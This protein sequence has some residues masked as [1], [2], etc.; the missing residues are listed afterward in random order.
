MATTLSTINEIQSASGLPAAIPD[1]V[2]NISL[3][4][5]PAI[6][7]LEV[8]AGG[9]KVFRPVTDRWSFCRLDVTQAVSLKA[10]AQGNDR[11]VDLLLIADRNSNGAIDPGELISSSTSLGAGKSIIDA[12]I[13][14]GSYILAACPH[15]LASATIELQAQPLTT[16]KP[17]VFDVLTGQGTELTVPIT[18]SSLRSN[19]VPFWNEVARQAVRN[20]KPGP[21]IASRAYGIVNTA[22]YDAW[23]A[24]DPQATGVELNNSWQQT[25]RE[26]TLENKIEAISYAAYRSLLDLFPTQ[27]SLID[28]ALSAIGLDPNN[29]RIDRT[30]AAGIGNAAAS[31]VLTTRHQDGSNQLG[32]R[33]TGAYADYTG[34]KPLNQP[35]DTTTGSTGINNPD[36]WQPL[37]T[38]D[39]KVQSFLTP[40]WGQVKPFGLTSGAQF[41]PAAPPAFGSAEYIRQAEQVLNI[42]AAL[43]DRQKTIAEFWEDGGGTSFPPG[44]WIGIGQYASQ[45]DRH[46][47]DQDI[48]MFFALGNAVMDAGIAAWETKRAYDS[49]RPITEI[50]AV[51]GN[52][53]V[54]TWGGPGQGTVTKPGTQFTPYQNTASPTPPF[55]SYVSGHSTFS[56][57]A[58][59]ILQRATGSDTFGLSFTQPVGGNR[60]DAGKTPTAPVSLSWATY[61]DA[62]NESGLSRI[63][64]GIHV[65]A[66]NVE[67]L[68]LG[69][70]VAGAVW[71]RAQAYINGDRPS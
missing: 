22:M 44:S 23:S 5:K 8:A 9:G 1:G 11:N 21:T 32:D 31:A 13:D 37:K 65:E 30:S 66:D 19:P 27:K 14:P 36:H 42:S 7:V 29:S 49:A 4:A 38:P 67:G 45:R 51:K 39:G 52:Q 10:I 53:L 64:G 61:S 35:H 48:K 50:A 70:K 54:Q 12:A 41:R 24:Y 17:A 26:N 34:Y 40:Q 62:A 57:A 15:K 25:A 18:P 55:A 46:T 59:E 33:A 16:T 60:Y 28:G 58:A 6:N 20:S 47:L 69:R 63:Y 68:A 43:T 71:D 2:P 3:G 56:A